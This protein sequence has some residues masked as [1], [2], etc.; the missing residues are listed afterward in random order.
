MVSFINNIIVKTKEK[1]RYTKVVEEIVKRLAENNWFIKLKKYKWKVREVG[2]LGV[3]IRPE[4]IKIEQEKVKIVLD[5][6]TS[7][8]VKN[9]LKFLRFANYYK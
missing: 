2:F 6:L 4:E 1:K 9:V 7:S 5:W 3:V 8:K